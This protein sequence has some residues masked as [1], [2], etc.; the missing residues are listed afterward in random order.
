[1]FTLIALGTGVAW[2]YSTAANDVFNRI[3]GLRSLAITN[4]AGVNGTYDVQTYVVGL[5][6]SVANPA[7]VATLNRMASLGGTGQAYLASD[8]ASLTAAFA[9][10][11]T[12]IIARTGASSSVALTAGSWAADT[13]TCG[14]RITSISA[15]MSIGSCQHCVRITW[16]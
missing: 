11:S 16:M 8:S 7:S 1:M 4:N 15:S 2:T 3:T 13:D 10:I 14:S 12:D 6:D 9:R 5:G